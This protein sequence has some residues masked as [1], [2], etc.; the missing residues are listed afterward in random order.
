MSGGALVLT[1]TSIVL[2]VNV[3]GTLVYYAILYQ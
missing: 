2:P 3:G 1:P